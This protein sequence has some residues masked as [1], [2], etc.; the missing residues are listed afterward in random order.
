MGSR[1]ERAARWEG[2][3][4]ARPGGGFGSSSMEKVWGE[5]VL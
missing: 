3:V 1:K 4:E 2:A 5:H